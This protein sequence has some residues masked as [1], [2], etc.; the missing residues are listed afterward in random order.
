MI[1]INQSAKIITPDEQSGVFLLKACEDRITDDSYFTFINN[2]IKRGHETPLEFAD[3]TF[4]L[5]TSRA[6]LAEITRHRLSSFCVESQRYIQ[7]AKTGNITFI[8]PEWY[9]VEDEAT[10]VWQNQI[11]SAE[12]AYKELI[13]LGCK[14]EQAREVLPNS[15]ACR[16]IMKANLREWR[17]IFELRTSKFAYPQMRTL[18]TQMLKL[19]NERVPIVFNDLIEG[20]Q[21]DE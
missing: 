6:V 5:T 11:Q 8:K 21:N 7:E 15:T 17:H 10:T 3:I 14:P 2:L 20:V 16:I 12:D 4:D 19:C 13:A 18:A 1:L 9:N